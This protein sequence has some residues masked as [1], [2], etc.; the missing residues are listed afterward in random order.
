M[1]SFK[2][3][4]AK[5]VTV[6][7]KMSADIAKKAQEVGSNESK[8]EFIDACESLKD[9]PQV[10]PFN[11]LLLVYSPFLPQIGPKV[12]AAEAAKFVESRKKIL[13]GIAK[14]M[15]KIATAHA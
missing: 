6:I 7:Q 3:I 8:Q 1:Q 15:L 10:H 12:I 9:F 5:G 14:G 11:P 13:E 2:E 4:K